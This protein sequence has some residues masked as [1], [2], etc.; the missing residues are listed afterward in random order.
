MLGMK[1]L[2]QCL[3]LIFFTSIF[4]ARANSSHDIGAVSIDSPLVGFCGSNQNIYV[5]VA[6]YGNIK[7]DSF[8][9]NWSI[10]GVLQSPVKR[11]LSIDTLGSTTGNTAF[12]YLVNQSFT[13]GVPTVIKVWTSLPND[14]VDVNQTND[15][16]TVSRVL[17]SLSG[18]YTVN[19]SITGSRN[20]SSIDNALSALN[21]FGICGPTVIAITPGIY[22]RITTLSIGNVVG[23]NSVNTLTFTKDGQDTCQIVGSISGAAIVVLNGSR[24]VT[25]RDISIINNS[26][27]NPVALAVVG[28]TIKVSIINCYLRVP[29]V[30]GSSEVGYGLNF[31]GTTNGAGLSSAQTD[32]ALVDSN[33][34]IG[35]GYGI[36]IIG[37]LSN[38]S[39]RN[40]IV[41]NNILES[42][43]AYGIY[44]ID[45]YNAIRISQNRINMH[46]ASTMARGIFFNNN[47]NNS[48]IP[49]IISQNDISHFVTLGIYCNNHI[50]LGSIASP[51]IISNNLMRGYNNSVS[52][53]INGISVSTNVGD[54]RI[55]IYHNTVLVRSAQTTMPPFNETMGALNLSGSTTADIKNNI[56]LSNGGTTIL[57][58]LI[59]SNLAASNLNYNIY[60]NNT[61]NGNLV[62]RNSSLFNSSNF[63][64]QLAGGDSSTNIFPP[65][66]DTLSLNYRLRH[67]CFFSASLNNI[68]QNDINNV[69]RLAKPTVG[70]YEYLALPNN[71]SLLD[72]ITPS[73]NAGPVFLGP[74]DVKFRI[75]NAGNNTLTSYQSAYR[76][77]NNLPIVITKTDSVKV[78]AIDTVV[79]TGANKANIQ[80]SQDIA[81]FTRNPNNN[82]D[83]ERQGDTI[84][85]NLFASL[86]G[87]YTIGGVNPDFITPQAAVA[88]L[89]EL[90]VSGHVLFQVRAGTYSG[91]VQISG[92]IMGL[93]DTS[94]IIFDGTHTDSVIFSASTTGAVVFI[95]Q[96]SYIT[97]RNLTI[98]NS[99][100][101][102]GIGICSPVTTRLSSCNIINCKVLL[103]V[104]TGFGN[105]GNGIL[106]TGAVNLSVAPSRADSILIDSCIVDGGGNGIV[107]SG[108]SDTLRNVNIVIRNNVISRSSNVAL[109][110]FS[111]YN[112]VLLEA[113]QISMLAI[114]NNYGARGLSFQDNRNYN[115]NNSHVISRNKIRNFREYGMFVTNT[116][117]GANAPT[118]IINNEVISSPSQSVIG[119]IYISQF[120]NNSPVIVSHNTVF[121]TGKNTITTNG[122]LM[123]LT[124]TNIN[125]RNNIFVVNSGGYHPLYM[126]GNQTNNI[127]NQNLYFNA[128]ATRLVAR[129]GFF[130]TSLNYK[131][132]NGGGEVSLNFKP[133]FVSTD[134]LAYN[135]TLVHKCMS[136]ILR[137]PGFIKDINNSLRD[138]MTTVGAYESLKLMNSLSLEDVITPSSTLS[139]TGLTD[140]RLLVRNSGNS[141]INQYQ[142]GY[143]FNNGTPVST[144]RT[145]SLAGC[146]VDTITFTTPNQVNLKVVNN[147]LKS[148][149]SSPNNQV[150]TFRLDDTL[151]N[152]Y[153]PRLSG[154][155]TIGTASADF[156]SIQQAMATAIS[157]GISGHVNFMIQPGTYQGPVILSGVVP[158]LSALS[159]IT[160]NGG[161]A[162]LVNFIADTTGAVFTINQMSH[163]KLRNI[164]LTNRKAGMGVF[165]NGSGFDA[166][167]TG[168]EVRNCRIILPAHN[169]L[170]TAGHAI[171]IARAFNNFFL[172]TVMD[173]IIIDSNYFSGG[174]NGILFSGSSNSLWNRKVEVTGNTFDSCNN[175]AISISGV[176]NPVIIARNIIHMNAR[177]S[178]SNGIN[179]SDNQI[180]SGSHIIDRNRVYNFGG[181]GISC[182]RNSSNISSNLFITNNILVSADS[183]TGTRSGL[184]GINLDVGGQYNA[185]VL[186]NT[187]LMRGN[188]I[189][190]VPSCLST[191]GS[192]LTQIYNNIFAVYK[193]SYTPLLADYTPYLNPGNIDANVYYVEGAGLLRNLVSTNGSFNATNYANSNSG[194]ARS[195]NKNPLFKN[196]LGIIPDLSLLRGCVVP[197]HFMSGTSSFD[198]LGKVRAIFPTVGA[199]EN[200]DKN[201]AVNAIIP[202]AI[203]VASGVQELK[204]TVQ[205]VSTDTLSSY[206]GA[207]I[208]N[209][210]PPIAINKSNQLK[211]CDIDTFTFAGVLRPSLVPVNNFKV[212][213]VIPSSFTGDD[214]INQVIYTALSGSYTIAKSGGYFNS[215]KEAV[216]GLQSGVVGPV[217]FQVQ[218]GIYNERLI[219]EGP[220]IGADNIRTISFEGTNP[221]NTVLSFDSN[222]TTASISNVPYISFYKL[223]FLSSVGGGIL[224]IDKFAMPKTSNI[225]VSNC[226]IT[227]KPNASYYGISNGD[228]GNSYDTLIVD[229]NKIY[230]ADHGIVVQG[231]IN[232]LVNKRTLI[233]NNFIENCG[234][235][236][237]V[238]R[239][240]FNKINIV[241]NEVNLTGYSTASTVG[242]RLFHLAD[243]VTTNIKDTNLIM[244]NRVNNFRDMG[245]SAV[246]SGGYNRSG[247]MIINNV[248]TS[249][250]EGF[251]FS[252]GKY[253]IY[254]SLNA[255]GTPGA[256]VFHNSVVMQGSSTDIN[257]AALYVSAYDYNVRNNILAVYSGAYTAFRLSQSGFSP[258]VVNHNLYH[259]SSSILPRRL[260]NGFDSSN[261]KNSTGGDSSF[262]VVPP[263]V[264]R[265]YF[266]S[267]LALTDQC[268][269]NR[270]SNL[271]AAVPNDINNVVRPILPTVGAFEF[272]PLANNVSVKNILSPLDTDSFPTGLHDV[273]YRVINAGTNTI[274]QYTANYT[275]NN[276]TIYSKLRNVNL[277]ACQ[278]DT[279]TFNA[280]EKVSLV[281][282]NVLTA[283][284]SNPNSVADPD[285]LADTTRLILTPLMAGDYTIGKAPSDFLTIKA[286]NDRL[287]RGIAGAVKLKLKSGSYQEFVSFTNVKGASATN[288][289]T[290]TS[291]DANP[292]SVLIFQ[293]YNGIS[294]AHGS[295]L[296]DFGTSARHYIFDKLTLQTD[297]VAACYVIQVTGTASYDTVRNC[298]IRQPFTTGDISSHYPTNIIGT[299]YTGEGLCLTGNKIIGGYYSLSM[300]GAARS[301][302]MKNLVFENNQFSKFYYCI[303][304]YR[305]GKAGRF[306]KNTI[307][308]DSTSSQ[309]HPS[310]YQID[311]GFQI[312]A[313]TFNGL[314][315]RSLH[316]YLDDCKN[317]PNNKCIIAN[318]KFSGGVV[319]LAFSGNSSNVD[320]VHN[321]VSGSTASIEISMTNSQNIRSL[322]NV[323]TGSYLFS[324]SD[325]TGLTS[326]Y[327]SVQSYRVA[328]T[329]L[330]PLQFK[331][332]YKTVEV[333]SVNAPSGLIS[334]TNPTPDSSN[335]SSWSLNGTGTHIGY[336]LNDFNNAPRP[337]TFIQGTPDIGAQEFTPIS[338]PAALTR[339][340]TSATTAVFLLGIDTVA[341]IKWTGTLP[342]S[343]VIGRRYTGAYPPNI[344]GN[345]HK[346]LNLYWDFT[347]PFG[348]YNYEVDLF[349]R[350]PS[351]GSIPAILN[352]IGAQKTGSSPWAFYQGNAVAIDS[353]RNILTIK[354]LTNFSMLTGTDLNNPL[355]VKLLDFSALAIS[356]NAS[357]QWTTAEEKNVSHFEVYAS[358]N[359]IDYSR[360]GDDIKAKGNTST[361]TVYRYVDND[362]FASTSV[363]YYRLKSVDING[364]DSWSNTEIVS[365]QLI[366]KKDV[367]VYPN[368]FSNNITIYMND[369][370]L[371]DIM[372]SDLSGR[373]LYHRGL[374]PNNNQINLL[375]I[376]GLNSGIYLITVKQGNEIYSKKL[377]KN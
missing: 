339:V 375:D 201:I 283:F 369:N 335:S 344:N 275:N 192:Q 197:C 7:V 140:V 71:I 357:L 318:N 228:V 311:S 90:G 282:T 207:Y 1:R 292:D 107:F 157:R 216:S 133:P 56:F 262:T 156:S 245:I 26:T 172:T 213:S 130:F 175:A 291:N 37:N 170:A 347:A 111:I 19:P 155:L 349:Y 264:N 165:I 284:T 35:G 312:T 258:S 124:S 54:Y 248:V 86:K 219:I 40:I 169:Q 247:V 333:N 293:K 43:N 147:S 29:L 222:S 217:K 190:Y 278:I 50:T 134:S 345:L 240:I 112:P 120:F 341:K 350:Y 355:P 229:S 5:R 265:E 368:P 126:T 317:H 208:L 158:G 57:P 329:N 308:M 324:S 70:A 234:Q 209:N 254:V 44:V 10:N 148:F 38:L 202:F 287:Q 34:V 180:S 322:N 224:F 24:Y 74:Q 101:G 206:Q 304:Y 61:A 257:H 162:N 352:M 270:G 49:H 309:F 115:K 102:V 244:N 18:R 338:I 17:S 55:R 96:L 246:V 93:S 99:S 188:P 301:N 123:A 273:K 295:S 110:V 129:D 117:V 31:T 84:K 128:V 376:D 268:G 281:L 252:S 83:T 336:S 250:K 186:H 205:N 109:N 280:S 21:A 151:T 182:A 119:G 95:N 289:I 288:T 146:G 22:N 178:F 14:T 89:L 243:N 327:N 360:I 306:S 39:N 20:F 337:Q 106:V 91:Q 121:V 267:N 113:N 261:F 196:P 194:G 168:C 310:F 138:S 346:S 203:P 233:S 11:V 33:R 163:I 331:T 279:V 131:T 305:Y 58:V 200:I 8:M 79:F 30:S 171:R 373:L 46:L 45:N 137:V 271:T 353:V 348:S 47:L 241:N 51:T 256:N 251:S 266:P 159:N 223:G 237:I 313:N 181:F 198:N 199:I 65:F 215:F 184:S 185:S 235:N 145:L 160:F 53:S 98:S 232:R 144:T 73:N 183:S 193:G 286:A 316:V 255:W 370:S 36:S 100:A 332:T 94:R 150:D 64:T 302:G 16:S 139:K 204:F 116:S 103:P 342:I 67:G 28:T 225:R 125:I 263:F 4:Q 143:I 97:L 358:D 42:V 260:V 319:G 15:T 377:I 149:V 135:L 210:N 372:I 166:S 221:E 314:A 269:L 63:L 114:G 108:C 142:A 85:M 105:S 272:V 212:Y 231:A 374:V 12:V 27:V 359:G 161:D 367:L 238:A 290:F 75:I 226:I 2:I 187:V 48:I 351:R 66:F 242:I 239:E 9:L 298:I 52:V 13:I 249:A 77:G 362:A 330:T 276:G 325:F 236:G 323:T 23:T 371:T 176:H 62:K 78:C 343:S 364:D 361:N 365:R 72:V 328:S 296:I 167:G 307:I 191:R 297:G 218:P 68:V 334:L 320:I 340:S 253:G 299:N 211:P 195:S 259:N 136:S 87:N 82:L 88:K 303:R 227:T 294:Y 25:F 274:N 277:G 164:T 92:T 214:T 59:S 174:A 152:N 60:F 141:L 154:T 356:S 363:R 69:T 321:T 189:G 118:N 132:A 41:S 173:S 6:N 153:L 122:A 32:S 326:D 285:R 3:F 104:Q 127:V 81:F 177:D 366:F 300:Q 76:I 220:I 80:Q 230:N 179:F 315:N 354:G